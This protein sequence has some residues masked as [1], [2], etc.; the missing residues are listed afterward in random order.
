MLCTRSVREPFPWR[1]LMY[2]FK[3]NVAV[4]ACL[5]VWCLTSFTVRAHGQVSSSS[6]GMHMHAG[7]L[8]NQ[9]WPS[10]SFGTMRLWD[11]EVQWAQINPSQGS[12]K[13]SE[14]DQWLNKAQSNNLTVIYS[15]GRTPRWASSKP[16]DTT[17]SYG[18]GQCDP[19]NDLNA[20][21]TGTNQHWKDFV[22][23]IATHSA[24]RIKIWEIWNEAP[25]AWYWTGTM[26]QMVRMASDARSIIKSID[27]SATVTTPSA[28]I[29]GM[30]NRDW[31]A[32]Y[33][34]A[35]GGQ[36]ADVIAFH[37]YIQEGGTYPVPE[38]FVTYFRDLKQTL[39]NHNQSSKPVYDT[40]FSWGRASRTGFTDKELQAGF[41]ARS[42]LLH[43]SEGVARVLWYEWNSTDGTGTLWSS[44]SGL[45]KPGIAYREVRTWLVGNKFTSRCAGTNGTWKCTLTRPD[46]AQV[47]AVWSTNGSKTYTASSIY[48]HYRD[49]YGTTHTIASSGAVTIGYKPI[50][51]QP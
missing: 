20:D 33:L 47:Q 21:G 6:F 18:A 27:P 40:E 5:V 13:W 16:N 39:A 32:N 46:S 51:L 11:A 38:D 43:A 50:L 4:A 7:V 45:L 30:P 48:R 8:A 41:V 29:R 3:N 28:G 36:Y 22:R 35:G 12:Y 24:G 10:V 15:F 34:A 2:R 23:A 49:V 17:C 31:T 1:L 44:S 26:K 9:P 37:G 42:L 19:P 14:L 25:N